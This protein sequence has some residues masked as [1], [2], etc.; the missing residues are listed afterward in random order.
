MSKVFLAISTGSGELD[1]LKELTSN[2]YNF[3]GLAVT[4]HGDKEDEEYKLLDS[5]K[6]IGFV[7]I[8]PYYGHHGHD[9]NHIL[10]NPIIDQSSWLLLRDSSERI[11]PKFSADLKNFILSLEQN[12][13]N[14]VYNYSKLLLFKRFPHQFFVNTP[15]W[16]LS[17]AHGNILKL[18]ETG[19]FKSEEEYC[20]S[21]RNKNRDKYHFVFHYLRYYCLLDSNHCLLG[22]EQDQDRFNQRESL[23]RQFRAYCDGLG[24]LP[25]TIDKFKWLYNNKLDDIKEYLN[26]E[27]ILNDAVRYLVLGLT[28]FNDDHDFSNMIKI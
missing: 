1:N 23:R 26:K 2:Y 13:V 3:D 19:W 14:T 24:I 7:E 4:Y 5:R 10:F 6:G 27:K 17:G 20:Y 25:M 22:C 18:D 28:D 12:N 15:H 16:G 21:N 11:N 8:I 9:L